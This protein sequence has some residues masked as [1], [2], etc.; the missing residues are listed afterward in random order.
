MEYF[1]SVKPRDYIKCL[2][3]LSERD[4][5]PASEL[6]P[7]LT[8]DVL[9]VER[10]LGVELPEDY[11]DFLT[12]VG[13]GPE[14]GG[15]AWWYHL[16]ITRPGNILEVNHELAK[17][18]AQLMR[19]AGKAPSDFPNGFLAIYDACDGEVFGF[20]RDTKGKFLPHVIAWDTEDYTSQRIA[21]DLCGFLDFLLE[22]EEIF[23]TVI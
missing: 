12:I 16:D 21:D 3:L 11:E 5:L 17:E 20:E 18:Q 13:S 23:L 14:F 2:E 15:V 8:T 7:A 22:G 19:K 6:Y 1:C 9:T 4:A 10:E